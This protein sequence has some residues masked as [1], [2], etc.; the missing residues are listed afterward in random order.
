VLPRRRTALAALAALSVAA[1]LTACGGPS[2]SSLLADGDEA[3]RTS[4]G[5]ADAV[6]KPTNYPELMEAARAL[7]TAT[8]E[9]EARLRKLGIPDGDK[10]EVRPILSAIGGVAGSARRLEEASARTD[11]RATS[12]A[13][14]EVADRSKDAATRARAYGFN[15]CG[16][17]TEG[18]AGTVFEGAKGIVKA[19]FVARA[20]GLC[21]EAINQAADLREPRTQSA[22]PA[23][24]DALLA[25]EE[26]VVDDMRALAVPPG[27]QAAVA[28]LID[29]R[30]KLNSKGRELTGAMRARNGARQ[31]A[32][33]DELAVLGT[34]AA[35]KADAYGIRECGTGSIL[36]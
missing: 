5:P 14:G 17:N 9:Q 11:D 32:L 1:A 22:L 13:A 36:G 35:A 24:L 2:K 4:S 23:Y 12:D 34:A 21:R 10:D 6:K 27:D 26:K 20:Q 30:A 18:P 28:E 16:V 3:C 25:L 8:G 19:A 7:A 15:A 33:A 31:A 29:A